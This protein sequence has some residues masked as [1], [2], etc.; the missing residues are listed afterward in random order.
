MNLRLAF[1][2]AGLLLALGTAVATAG[3]VL[4]PAAI[5]QGLEPSQAPSLLAPISVEGRTGW[6]CEP[7]RA[8]TAADAQ[9]AHLPL[10]AT[11]K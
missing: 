3:A 6:A 1:A 9:Q 11:D 2:M 4:D 8:A 7:E 10:P 5:E